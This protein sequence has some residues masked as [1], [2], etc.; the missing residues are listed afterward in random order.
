MGLTEGAFQENINYSQFLPTTSYSDIVIILN[1]FEV[2]HP[3]SDE[4]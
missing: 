4:Y 3:E 1:L 2:G